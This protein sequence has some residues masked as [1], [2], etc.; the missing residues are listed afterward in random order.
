MQRTLRTGVIV[1]AVCWAAVVIASEGQTTTSPAPAVVSREDAEQ[2]PIKFFPD[3]ANE[4]SFPAQ[5]ARFV[6]LVIAAT[7]DGQACIDELEIYAEG[8]DDNLALGLARCQRQCLVLLAGVHDPSS[9]APERRAVRQ[10]AQLD[11][12]R[13]GE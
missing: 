9:R 7:A 5:D 13:P 12:R 11:C 3:V 4:L 1:V 6:R 10:C 2:Q 8:G